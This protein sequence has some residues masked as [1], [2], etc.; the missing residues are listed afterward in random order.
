MN[1]REFK[2]KM[3]PEQYRV[4]RQKGTE[5]PHAGKYWD[6]DG[7][8]LYVCA[9]CDNV[10][11]SSLSKFEAGTGWPTFRGPIRKKHIELR[12]DAEGQEIICASC[13]SHLG[14]VIP[15]EKEHYRLNSVALR[16]IEMGDIEFDDGD[17]DDK[18][19][20]DKHDKP[21]SSAVKNITLTIG[22]LAIGVA[23]GAAAAP[24]APPAVCLPSPTPVVQTQT[25]KPTAGAT[26]PAV[27]R[28]VLP[29][30]PAASA[31]S[32]SSAAPGTV[33]TP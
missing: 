10:L 25:P 14:Y 22:G 32:S 33:P 16:F 29:I 23:I 6:S 12:K 5:T 13:Q 2:D 7:R 4:M 31:V 19:K 3:T 21:K 20:E 15:G 30:P 8:G 11:F 1:E 26:A 18:E 9:A 27:I 28:T 24:T 17:E